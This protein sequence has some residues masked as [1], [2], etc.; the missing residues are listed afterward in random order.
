MQVSASIG[1]TFYPQD[2][3]D[4]DQVMR[5]ADQAMYLAKQAGKNR[6]QIFDIAL[7]A[8]IRS[9]RED[10]QHIAD[11]LDQ[12][13]FVL[14]YQPNVNMKTGQVTGAEA[15]I[16]WRHPQRGLLAPGAFLPQV[17]NHPLCID[18]GEW[19]IKT[20]LAQMSAWQAQ[21]LVIHVSVNIDARHL[22]HDGF[23]QQLAVLFSFQSDVL[24]QN[25]RLEV[26]ESSIMEDIGKVSSAMQSCL[27]LG[28][29]FS[30]D[31]FGTGS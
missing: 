7:D 23:A 1:M 15:L 17:Q 12:S 11:A 20:A 8:A 3:V 2:N 29:D 18:I 6:Y 14:H 27:A 13:E 25:L 28:V 19:V 22:Q 24:P 9:R 4:A 26:L 16:R 30:L 31:D 21:G 10:L 5:Q